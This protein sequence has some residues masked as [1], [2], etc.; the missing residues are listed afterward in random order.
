MLRTIVLTAG[1]SMHWKSRF[2]GVLILFCCHT[3][4]LGYIF[5]VINTQ[6]VS[7]FLSAADTKG[8]I[9]AF[10]CFPYINSFPLALPYIVLIFT[11]LK[12]MKMKLYY[13]LLTSLQKTFLFTTARREEI[14]KYF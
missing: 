7:P 3:I 14:H 13:L 5:Q 2:I 11:F 10:P 9:V 8:I 6:W 1:N 12:V 4:K